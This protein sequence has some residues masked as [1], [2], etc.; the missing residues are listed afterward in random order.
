MKALVVDKSNAMR[1]VLHR[2]LSQ[3]GIEV[4]EAED[5]LQALDVFRIMGKADLVLASWI[6]GERSNL[7]FI[8][9]MRHES[10]HNTMVVLLAAHQPDVRELHS[11][12]IAGADDYLMTPFTAIQMD[13]KLEQVGLDAQR[14]KCIAKQSP[15]CR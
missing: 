15:F 13:E 5:G 8:A 7:D 9:R 12:F 2:M 1:S 10:A 6:P 3:R 14:D 11:A 4:A